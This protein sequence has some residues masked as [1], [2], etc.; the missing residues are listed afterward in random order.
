MA[1]TTRSCAFVTVARAGSVHAAAEHLF[2]SQPSVSAALAALA[3]ELDVPLVER[4]GRG[5]RL[6]EAGEA[7]LPYATQVLGLVDEGRE[8]AHEAVRRE[9]A[10]VRVVA[11]N[12]AG[13]YLLPP[14]IQ[15][16]RRCA[17]RVEVLLEI[18]NRRTLLD[19]LVSHEADIGVGGRAPGREIMGEAFLENELIVVGR[20]VPDDLGQAVWL[21][22]ED[23]SGTRAAT[24][25]F[26]AERGPSPRSCSRSARTGPSSRRS[27]SGSASLRL[28]QPSRATARR[29]ARAIRAGDA[30]LRRGTSFTCGRPLRPAVESFRDFLLPG[31]QASDRK[32]YSSAR[33]RLFLSGTAQLG[34]AMFEAACAPT[35]MLRAGLR[36]AETEI[37]AA[38]RI[39]PQPGVPLKAAAAV[40]AES[41]TGTWTSV[42]TETG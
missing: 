17:P 30:A 33:I 18:G 31:G 35:G 36:A 34:S 21:L 26:L 41:S 39:T 9:G 3:R 27:R 2:V 38:F 19:R 37:L 24:E 8:A 5:V 25:R 22:R 20:T 40:A 14:L 16:F 12:T 4:H 23:G 32:L 29:L 7:Y 42:W 13:E 28:A 11:V 15:A 1:V 6:T 10:R